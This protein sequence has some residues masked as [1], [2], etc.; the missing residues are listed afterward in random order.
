MKGIKR[1]FSVPRTPQQNRI[2]ERKNRSLIEAARTMLADSL[3]P[4]PFWAEAVNTA[5]YVHNRVLVTKPQNKTPYELLLGRTPSIGFMRPFGCPATIFN[6]LDPLGK[7]DRKVDEGFLVGY[8]VSS[9]AFRVFN[10]RTRIIQE[11]LHINFLE[12]KP[13]VVSSGPTWLFDIDTLTKT[14]NYQPV[15][16]GNQS[17]LSVGIQ[18]QFDAEKAEEENVQQYVLFLVWSSG[19]KNPQNIDDD[20]AF[21]GEK[22]EFKGRK[23]VSVSEVHVSPSSKFEYFSVNNINE[24]NVADSLVPA[25][26]QISTN[27]TN[28]FSADELEDIIYSDDEEDVGAEADFNNLETTITVSPIPT[29]RVHKDHPVTQTIGD[30]SSTTLT[31][32]M[33]RVAKDQGGLSQINNDDFHTCMC[34]Y[35]LSQEEPKRKV[36]VLVDLP[37]G[38]RAIG[39]K[40]VFRNKKDERGIVVRNKARVVV[41]GYT[42][43]EGIDYKKVFAPVTRIKAIR[44]FLAYASFMGFMVCQMDVKSAFLYE[45]IKEEVYVCQP[46]GFEDPDYPDKVYKV[47]KALYGLHQAPRACKAEARWDFISQDK[48][49]TKIL[50]KFGLTNGKSASTPMDTEKPLLKDPDGEDVD[51]YTYRSMIGS[52]MY[53]T[54]LRLDIMFAVCAC[55]RFQ[56]T[57]KAS[58]LY[59]VKRIFRYLKGKPHLGLW[60]PKDSPFNLVAYSNSDYAGVND[61]MR[62]QALVNKKKVIFIEATIR[63]ALRLD[64]V[65]SIDCL[66]NEEIFTKLSRMGSSMASVVICL[67]TGR[68]FKFSKYIFDSLVRNV[69]SFTKFYMYPQFLQLMIRAEVGDHSSYSTKYSSPALTQ[70]VFANIRRVGKGFSGVNTPLFEGMIV[71][72]QDD[73]VADEGTI[74]VAIDD[75]LAAIYKPSIPSPTPTTQPP[76]PSQD[77]PSTLQVLPTLPPSPI[78]Q[79]PLPQQQLQHLQPSHDAEISMDLLH[80]LLETYANEDVTLKDVA[81]VAK[82]VVAIEKD[83][84]IEENADVQGRKAESQSQIY[85][86][87]LEHADK[88]LSIQDDEVEPAELQERKEKEDNDVMRYQALKRKPQIKAQAR[89][90]MMIYLRNM[91]GFNMDYF[92]GMSYDDIRPIFE[93]KFNSN[94]QMSAMGELTFFLSLQVLQKKD[95]I[96]LSQ[97]KYVG[98]ILKK[99]G[100]SDVRS[101]NTPMGKENPWGKD[102]PEY[103]A[104][105]SGCRQVLWIQNQMLDYGIETT[106]Q[107]TKIIA[108]VDGKPRTISKSSLRRHLKLNDKEGISSLPDAE[109]FENLSL[110]G[111]NILPSQRTVP[112][113][114]SMIVTQGEGLANPTD[115]ITHPHRRNTNHL[116]EPASLSRDDR[117]EEAFSTVS[118]LDVGQDRENITKISAMSYESSPRVPSLDADESSIQQRLH[119]LMELCTSPQWQQSQMADKIKDQDIEISGL[120][121]RIKS[122]EDKEK[123]REETIQED[124]P[125]TRG[126]IDIREELGA[127]KSTHKGVMILRRCVSPADVFPTAG[128]PTVSGSFPTVS[129]IF[130]TASMATAYIRRSRGITIGSLQPI[131]IP[132][133]SAKDKGKEKVTETKVPKKKKLQEQIDAQVAREME[134][135]FAR[136]NQRLSEQAARD[137]EIARIHAEEELNLMIEGLDRSNEVIAKHLSEYEQ[138]KADLSVGEKIELISERVK[139]QDYLVKILKYQA[140]QSKPSSKKEQRKFYMSVL[141]S[142]AGWKTEHFR[143]MTLEQIKEKFIPVWKHLQDFVPMYSKEESEKVKRPGI[144]LDQGSSKGVKISHTLR[145]KPSQEQQFKGSKGVSMEELKGMM[146]LVPLEEVYIK[147]LQVKHPIIDWEIHYKGKREYWKIIRLG[148]TITLQA[149]VVDL[150]LGIN[151]SQAEKAAKKQNLDEEVEELKKHLQIVPNDKDD[152][153]T[154]ATPLTRKVPVVDYEIYTENNKPYYKIIRADGSPQLF[155][156]FLSLLRNFDREDLEVL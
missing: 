81:A 60:Y 69:Y 139:Y 4:I 100:Y 111:Y 90:N 80:T 9:K 15:T 156:S 115:L 13:N 117:H 21:R 83:A 102:G 71:A 124:A 92:K 61:V 145:S 51:M 44:L 39:T 107:E 113:F 55:A 43:E 63:E 16:A 72:Q 45:T 67:S 42:Q 10:S 29:T 2:A 48:Y 126:I 64:D 53:L 121:A 28:T 119:K 50:R 62:L 109:I 122:L 144:K 19:S 77:L 65:E 104:A 149:K 6:T 47:V 137:S 76:P 88:V 14:M 52:L 132:I 35:F 78:A 133:I 140:Q 84:D 123:R 20:A 155:L 82:D 135:E 40:W 32:S 143:G 150:S 98:D 148:V 118:S 41:Q 134:E 96:F 3:L 152:V 31:R 93:K 34:A 147:A 138:A 59:A 154:E 130:T 153:Y 25:V 7:F 91:A 114:V 17:N 106:D 22:P 99:F 125:I 97:D 75:V 36:W 136:E 11:T 105:A 5:C 146:Q 26:R 74:S 120:K 8:Y 103:V 94:F 54:S 101:A 142:H 110:M 46:P 49:V 24:V 89:K 33:T 128:V 58:H 131:R 116:N 68:K 108:T 87:D 37:N 56:V 57:P 1:E 18:E 129:A 95:G 85:Q 141:K 79:P 12:N 70:K 30:L 112:L 127:D 66:P 38:K 27:S 151:K 73:D 23:S 86:I